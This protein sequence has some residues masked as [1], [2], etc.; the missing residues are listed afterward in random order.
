MTKDLQNE[1]KFSSL[2]KKIQKETELWPFRSIEYKEITN[3]GQQIL[4]GILE[5]SK[6]Q[7]SDSYSVSFLQEQDKF[8]IYDA[9][10]TIIAYCWLDQNFSPVFIKEFNT[11]RM[12]MN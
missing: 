3:L 8:I 2:I 7:M 9:K 12:R 11:L 6:E 10:G 5:E 1:T 4:D